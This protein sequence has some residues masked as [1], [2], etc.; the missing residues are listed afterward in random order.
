M[1]VGDKT[2]LVVDNDSVFRTS[3]TD[4][5]NRAG[6]KAHGASDGRTAISIAEAL[7]TDVDVIV[8]D[9][10]LP[11]MSGSVLIEA[12]AVHQAK[13]IKVI[14]SSSLFSQ[15][16]LDKQTSFHAVAGIRKESG[17]APAIAAR[18]LLTAR[19]LLGELAV[20]APAPLPVLILLADDD[21]SVR[22][23]VKAILT[24]HGYQV[25][26]AAD[27][28]D[29]LALA[30]KVAGAVDLLVTDIEM[31]GMDGRA[32]ATAIREMYRS[33]PVIYISGFIEN[34]ELKYL[35]APEERCAFLSKPFQARALLETIRI[36][37]NEAKRTGSS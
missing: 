3:L 36:L 31:P 34:P 24:G 28:Y 17:G 26:E 2:I 10:T 30:R 32:L 21:A 6:Y 9:M 33:V 15:A 35:H 5:L 4:I 13:T 19:S 14:A 7:G 20:P 25:L 1:G 27:G 23:F 16:D 37:L 22:H 12:I 8:L 18:W 11:D 29:A